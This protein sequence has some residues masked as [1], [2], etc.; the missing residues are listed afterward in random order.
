MLEELRAD[1]GFTVLPD[2][3]HS[4]NEPL[5]LI[6]SKAI[7]STRSNRTLSNVGVSE[8]IVRILPA[9]GFLKRLETC[10]TSATMQASKSDCD[11]MVRLS[12]TI[13]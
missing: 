12:V 5:L 1:S 10:T 2:P 6:L 11:G 9:R 13:S 4:V 8:T 3:M 7:S